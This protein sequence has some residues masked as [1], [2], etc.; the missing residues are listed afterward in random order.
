MSTKYYVYNVIEAIAKKLLTDLT[1]S[2][3]GPTYGSAVHAPGI[4]SVSVNLNR[5]VQTL[6][7]DGK[8]LGTESSITEIPV[9]LEIAQRDPEFE[10][11]LYGMAAWRTP[12][13][14]NLSMT[15]NS[16]PNYVGLWL[17][18]DRVGV[19]GKDV[20]IFIPKFQAAGQQLQQ[21]QRQFRTNQ[22]SG[23][24]VF[25]QSTF[26]VF[27]DG[28]LAQEA[29]AFQEQFRDTGAPLLAVSSDVT[30]PT[31]STANITGH[32]I[33]ADIV[34]ATVE[35]LNPNT[36]NKYTVLLK[37]GS[38]IGSGTLVPCTVSI[39]TA[40]TSI[41]INPTSSLTASSSYNVHFTTYVEDL[42]GNT[43]AALSGITVATA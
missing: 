43:F 37:T 38:T 27:R 10:A 9:T 22:I 26:E 2:L 31:I 16:T 28:V 42:V 19:N 40:G 4:Q 6:Q 20:V 33:S 12:T 21:Q 34:I 32:V 7:G 29:V 35:A 23:G 13:E 25:T 15:D 17:R 24:G 36:V 14:F 41:T 18:T 3:T 1:S 39:N 5:D 30:A 8:I 11:L